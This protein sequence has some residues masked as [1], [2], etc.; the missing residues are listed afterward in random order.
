MEVFEGS[1]M[2]FVRDDEDDAIA[3]ACE[4]AIRQVDNIIANPL[5]RQA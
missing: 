3:A 4:E 5:V 2:Q 1:T